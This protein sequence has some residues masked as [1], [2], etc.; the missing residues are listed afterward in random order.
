MTSLLKTIMIFEILATA[1]EF[2]FTATS[3]LNEHPLLGASTKYEI[4]VTVVELNLEISIK[5]QMF[6]VCMCLM[7]TLFYKKWNLAV[8]QMQMNPRILKLHQEPDE[9]WLLFDKQADKKVELS[10]R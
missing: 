3:F 2:K 7:S 5:Y 8:F 9:G 4:L 1:T 10:R 6:A